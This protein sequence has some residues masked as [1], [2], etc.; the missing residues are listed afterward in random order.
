MGWEAKL[1]TWKPWRDWESGKMDLGCQNITERREGCRPATWDQKACR[2]LSKKFLADTP[3]S[4]LLPVPGIC[5]VHIE[6]KRIKSIGLSLQALHPV[7]QLHRWMASH[8]VGLRG[9]VPSLGPESL[10][11][12][13]LLNHSLSCRPG[14]SIWSHLHKKACLA[15]QCLG[16]GATWS[17][18]EENA[19]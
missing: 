8:P 17:P 14:A 18:G 7:P 12:F 13:D 2:N 4:A 15:L 10:H 16:Q 11:L 3:H 6:T 1:C 19:L 5:S 9:N